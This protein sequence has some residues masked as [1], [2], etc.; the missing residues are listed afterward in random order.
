MISSIDNGFRIKGRFY[1]HVIL[2][3][4]SK[5]KKVKIRNARY[6][7]ESPENLEGKDVLIFGGGDLAYDNAL[8]IRRSGARVTLVRRGP[9]KA[10]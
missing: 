3:T 10:N 9:A 4:G 8:R 6:F 5:P 7:I 2:A 1:S